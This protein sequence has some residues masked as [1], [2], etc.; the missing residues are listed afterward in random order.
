MEVPERSIPGH[1]EWTEQALLSS[2]IVSIP[3]AKVSRLL[4][5]VAEV[6]V[7]KHTVVDSCSESCAN[8]SVDELEACDG[9]A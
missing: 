9:H 2:W 6:G 7:L 3:D 1:C 5:R 8:S 4:E